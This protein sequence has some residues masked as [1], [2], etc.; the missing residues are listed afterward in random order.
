MILDL[1]YQLVLG[2]SFFDLLKRFLQYPLNQ[3][4]GVAHLADFLRRFADAQLLK[5]GA[6]VLMLGKT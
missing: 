5:P 4:D 3:M 1:S 2:D 6:D